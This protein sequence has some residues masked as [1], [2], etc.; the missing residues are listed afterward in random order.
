MGREEDRSRGISLKTTESLGLVI[1]AKALTTT[2]PEG[3]DKPVFSLFL[4]LP[5]IPP[6]LAF[7]AFA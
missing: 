1:T 5:L 4:S 6:S 7:T 2:C 3:A